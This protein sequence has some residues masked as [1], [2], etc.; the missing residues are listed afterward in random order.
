MGYEDDRCDEEKDGDD[1]IPAYILTYV[2][3]FL[4]GK[5]MVKPNGVVAIKFCSCE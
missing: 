1:L 4:K 3:I 2:H 5:V